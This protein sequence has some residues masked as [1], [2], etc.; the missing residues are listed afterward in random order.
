MSCRGRNTFIFDRP[1]GIVAGAV[2]VG[3]KEGK[4]PLAEYFDY[5]APPQAGRDKNWEQEEIA[6]QNRALETVL[7]KGRKTEDAVDILLGGDLIDQITVTNFAAA[8]RD[9]PFLGL[10]N[11]CATMAEGMLLG[12]SLIGGGYARDA[13]VVTSSHNLTAERQYRFPTELGVQRPQYSQWTVTAAGSI[14]LS[15]EPADIEIISATV[16][17]IVDYGITDPN[18][19]GA[20]MAPAAADT[21]L[22]HLRNCGS[23]Y[24]DYDL[25]C[26][27]DLGGHGYELLCELLTKQ[28]IAVDERLVDGGMLIY[29]ATQDVHA[30]GSGAGCS[31]AVWNGYL[32]KV[33]QQRRYRRILLIGTGALLSSLSVGQSRTIPALAHAIEWE[34]GL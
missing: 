19:M 12:A 28:G 17:K 9:I 22:T 34:G 27:G 32:L 20:A 31:A 16:G 25:I 33:M 10:Y 1:V 2:A 13:A 8:E 6:L 7:R 11:A 24:E 21:I 4:G 18:E 23:D 30:G 14:L 26:T 5:I 29:D 3:A 15:S